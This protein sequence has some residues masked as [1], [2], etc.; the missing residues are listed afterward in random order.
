MDSN[1]F[2]KALKDLILLAQAEARKTESDGAFIKKDVLVAEFKVNRF[3]YGESG[4]G[5][6]GASQGYVIETEWGADAL[7]STVGRVR[8]SEQFNSLSENL[9]A[10]YKKD[11]KVSGEGLDLYGKLVNIVNSLVYRILRGTPSPASDP[12]SLSEIAFLEFTG[13]PIRYTVEIELQG[14]LMEEAEVSFQVGETGVR[15][16]RTRAE[17]LNL[18]FP[19][20]Q[21]TTGAVP[22]Y[23]HDTMLTPTGKL[24]V[25]A[26]VPN[27][28]EIRALANQGLAALRLFKVGGVESIFEK[29][30]SDS[31]QESM[32][33]TRSIGSGQASREKYH[34]AWGPY[35]LVA[36]DG[37]MLAK[38]WSRLVEHLP[39]GISK[40][41]IADYK[42]IAY[43]RYCDALLKNGLPERTVANAVMALESLFL[44]ARH[45]GELRYRLAVTV[46]RVMGI[47]GYDALS[48]KRRMKT[49]YDLRSRFVHGGRTTK[50]D[51]KAIAKLG[52]G[53]TLR[54]LRA[55][56]LE[57][58]RVGIICSMSQSLGKDDF[59][60]L[61]ENS[62]VS[63]D[64][65]EELREAL[66][67][68]KE[69]V[70]P[71]DL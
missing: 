44:P 67:L 47:L 6:Q 17:D 58:A 70:L 7:A 15:L 28:D 32:P 19:A 63:R 52:D 20:H 69:L 55:S 10:P 5:I 1:D 9:I 37:E 48:V 71:A 46:A 40:A 64:K 24:V 66:Q 38:F 26:R 51:Q 45:E 31:L 2:K 16:L 39:Q 36:G 12:D 49:A 61:V 62:L 30:Y 60:A 53:F 11:G 14:I 25:S 65:E 27:R 13:G 42:S 68:A 22:P 50:D 34:S 56:I 8:S 54:H 18:Q 33:Q 3:E 43:D 57:Y 59:L 35:R 23:F 41:K 21:L 4:G 29:L